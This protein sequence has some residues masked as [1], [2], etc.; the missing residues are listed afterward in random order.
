MSND[1]NVTT[2]RTIASEAPQQEQDVRARLRA[3][4]DSDR[5][6][7]QARIAR[8]AGISS[9]TMSQWLA[10]GYGGDNEAIAAKI[11]KWLDSLHAQ[12]AE[13]ERLPTAPDFVNTPSAERIIGT[14]RYAQI[15]GDIVLV[16]GGAG[17]GKT[18]SIRQYERIA[19]NVWHATM[20]PA[21][22]S[23]VT[24]LEEIGDALGLTTVNSGGAARLHR[25]I[26]KRVAETQ[27]LIVVDEAQHLS[28]AALDQIRSIHDATGIGIA[29]V[30]NEQVYARMTA[31]GTRAAYLDRLY[32]RIG[33]K[34]RLAKS[35]KADISAVL[36]AWNITDS[37]CRGQLE[38]IAS[39]PGGLRI[40]TKVLRLG[41]MYAAAAERSL[42]CDDVRSAWRELG[43]EA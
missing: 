23:V 43:V 30:G 15:A 25:A 2:L 20:T 18:T 10:G 4:M 11:A 16:Y 19:P 29:L 26:V 34:V 40:L 28:V 5:R 12:R 21:S 3:A 41:S 42:C 35:T 33:K 27:G 37:S 24:A 17:L 22:A 1:T 8:E 32:S 6:L 31:G 14:L 7:S 36:A 38:E 39:M 13:Q 9:T